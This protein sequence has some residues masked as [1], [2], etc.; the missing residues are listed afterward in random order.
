MSSTRGQP[1][2]PGPASRRFHD[3]RRTQTPELKLDL[4]RRF[5]QENQVLPV[6][7]LMLIVIVDGV[8]LHDIIRETRA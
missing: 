8:D 1:L 7:R 2:S 5:L 3:D 4:H 6:E